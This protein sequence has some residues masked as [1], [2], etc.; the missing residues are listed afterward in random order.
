MRAAVSMTSMMLEVITI[1]RQLCS[2]GVQFISVRFGSV[3]ARKLKSGAQPA[4]DDDDMRRLS[5]VGLTV[6]SAFVV[7][8]CSLLRWLPVLIYAFLFPTV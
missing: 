3:D 8:C 4:R 1:H 5:S 2:F 6:L 7:C